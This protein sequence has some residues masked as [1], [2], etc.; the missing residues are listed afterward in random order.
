MRGVT[1]GLIGAGLLLAMAASSAQAAPPPFCRGYAS[2]ALNQVYNV[3]YGESTTL[4]VL[5]RLIA[6]SL[7]RHRPQL[8]IEPPE[9]ADFRKG[10]VRH[11]LADI[12]KAQQL[13]GYAPTH[14]VRDGMVEAID[15][16]VGSLAPAG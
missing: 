1:T 7:R 9:H 8:A 14:S 12:G 13:L 6:D 5:H 10:D 11:S 15:W 3:A 4:N 2:A 16:Y